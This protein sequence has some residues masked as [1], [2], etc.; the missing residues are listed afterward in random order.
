MNPIEDISKIR[1]VICVFLSLAFSK[2]VK[3]NPM[4]WGPARN[5]YYQ[6]RYQNVEEEI[7]PVRCFGL[8]ISSPIYGYSKYGGTMHDY[9]LQISRQFKSFPL[10][11]DIVCELL[12]FREDFNF[13][14]FS[15][16]KNVNSSDD[17]ARFDFLSFNCK[18]GLSY[19][20]LG[21]N[22]RHNAIF[23]GA[24]IGGG[25]FLLDAFQHGTIL[26][27][28]QHETINKRTIYTRFLE[29]DSSGI[30]FNIN[31]GGR[32][33]FFN[34]F[35][36]GVTLNYNFGGGA[37]S[38]LRF[39]NDNGI[40]FLWEGEFKTLHACGGKFK[41]WPQKFKN[42]SNSKEDIQSQL[43]KDFDDKKN[44]F[45]SIVLNFYLGVNIPYDKE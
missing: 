18:L 20:F 32:I 34:F 11:F 36:F 40:E 4:F 3:A 10:D 22:E 23:L 7:K 35:Y 19:N 37:D 38:T 6:S 14:G 13:K 5:P 21:K 24:G 2:D 26:D 8:D 1:L 25:E 12:K 43:K 41:E 45:Y 27:A 16:K 28:F 42:T 9:G 29:L 44:K 17:N 39:F 33:S 30:F 15:Q 31:I